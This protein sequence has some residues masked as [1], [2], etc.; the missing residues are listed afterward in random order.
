MNR[1]INPRVTAARAGT[2]PTQSIGAVVVTG[3]QLE[4]SPQPGPG[5]SSTPTPVLQQFAPF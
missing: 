1:I 4:Q 2:R 3:L 5:V